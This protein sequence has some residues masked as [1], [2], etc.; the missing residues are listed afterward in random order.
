MKTV[1]GTFI[2]N[3]YEPKPQ[4][5]F[6]SNRYD[7][8][9]STDYSNESDSCCDTETLSSR[10][11]SSNSSNYSKSKKKK[12]Q[13]KK[14]KINNSTAGEILTEKHNE[15]QAIHKRKQISRKTQNKQSENQSYRQISATIVKENTSQQKCD[16]IRKVKYHNR[17][18]QEIPNR[19]PSTF[20]NAVARKIKEVV[21][22]TDSILKTL[23]MGKFNSCINEFASFQLKSFSGCKAMQLAHR[24]IPILQEQYYDAAGIH[25]GINDLLNSSSEKSIDEICPSHSIA[26]IFIS[27]IAYSTKVKLQLID[28]LNGLL[29]NPC[30]K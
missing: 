18:E 11:T 27:S 22:F 9:Y 29:Y 6:C 25:L 4:K 3:R 21:P 1:K 24:S 14:R 17:K 28:N 30:T 8:I 16:Q 12:K 10:S 15:N 26:T 23:H 5:V 2:K 19:L 20:N 7:T 13:H